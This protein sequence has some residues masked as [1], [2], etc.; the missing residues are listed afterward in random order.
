MT[1]LAALVQ[2]LRDSA[3]FNPQTHVAPS[4]IL[5]PDHEGQW[6]S[7]IPRLQAEIPELLV[8]GNLD[9]TKKTGPG[10]WLR[11]AI[12]N[13]IPEV[14]IGEAATPIIYLPG[15]SR[16][17]FRAVEESPLTLKPIIELQYRGSIWSHINGKDWTVQAILK[18]ESGGLGLMLGTGADNK[19]AMLLALEYVLDQNVDQLKGKLLDKA[20][21]S[22]LVQGGDL[23]RDV[24]TWLNRGDDYRS[25]IGERRWKAFCDVCKSSLN[26]NPANQ[27]ALDA[28]AAFASTDGSWLQI[29]NRYCESPRLYPNIPDRIPAS[30]APKQDIFWLTSE[31][32]FPGWPQWNDDQEVE[33][34]KQL[35]SVAGMPWHEARN[36]VISLE[37]DHGKRRNTVWAEL[38]R[39][40]SA[41]VLEQLAALA[42]HV[43]NKL[44]AGELA[45]ITE[46]YATTGWKV[47][48]A[49]M[50]ALVST[51]DFELDDIVREVVRALYLQ[52][53]EESARHL[54]TL[55]STDGYP[56]AGIGKFEPPTYKSGDCILF[57]DGLRFDLGKRLAGQ[58]QS[59]GCTVI[60]NPA[61]SALPSVTATAKPAVSPVAGL[62]VG[63]EENA[64]FEPQVRESAASLRGGSQLKRLL[65]DNGFSIVDNANQ[66]DSS[67][68]GWCE[69]GNIDSEGH[70]LGYRLANSVERLIQ[71][72]DGRV[73]Q[74]LQQG[75]KRVFVVTD[76]GWLIM[77][78]GLPKTEL[79]SFLTD[80]KW[81]RCA[82]IKSGSIANERYYPWFWNP[83]IQ[84]VLATGVSCYRANVEYSHGGLS[85]QECY[86]L[87]L[88]VTKS[89]A[90]QISMQMALSNVVWKHM[91]CTID[92]SSGA[93]GLT[94]DI[95]LQAANP[96]S[97]VASSTK[98]V[99][100]SC[101]T[102]VMVGDDS[103]E[104]K[105]AFV[106]VLDANGNVV[107]QVS[108]V[109]GR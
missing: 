2:S 80:S 76:H 49:A 10:I 88:C 64:D 33:L 66:G 15:V 31:G 12:A 78:G 5:W 9:A 69:F 70:S 61:W 96:D 38:G 35:A 93:V 48:E 51:S 102:F 24:L 77:P 16:A 14:Q 4:V 59:S 36:L 92:L 75:W 106:V 94:V 17:D 21:F 72:I 32:N 11:C 79:A 8:L 27:T 53:L 98:V 20:Y 84:F 45:D 13:L 101:S 54:Q 60:E 103:F 18:S 39:A 52:W 82:S 1:V 58:L 6:A 40:P 83:T 104:G 47:D 74:L 44:N 22:G 23:P 65:T 86:T 107:D 28:C 68:R 108:T 91:R 62:I 26:I 37:A 73:R 97:S 63:A 90:P 105:D 43:E 81:G 41:M 99:G 19:D 56:N 87:H 55:V 42:V 7:V 29:W 3:K 30:R 71:E 50:N 34:R 25:E 67:K 109:I 89:G 85:F 95:R 57:V 46:G 100:E